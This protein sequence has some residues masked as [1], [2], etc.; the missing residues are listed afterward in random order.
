M[1]TRLPDLVLGVASA[2]SGR[3]DEHASLTNR[4]DHPWS[5]R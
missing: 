5:E 1:T 4:Q 3:H 2:S